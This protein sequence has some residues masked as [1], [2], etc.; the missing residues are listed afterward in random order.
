MSDFTS[1]SSLVS[2]CESPLIMANNSVRIVASS[3]PDIEAW[4]SR[5]S[6]FESLLIP[7]SERKNKRQTVQ[8][9]AT[10]EQFRCGAF[11]FRFR[12]FIST[13]RATRPKKRRTHRK[14]EDIVNSTKGGKSVHFQAFI[15]APRLWRPISTFQTLNPASNFSRTMELSC[16]WSFQLRA[17]DEMAFWLCRTGSQD[18]L[19]MPYIHLLFMERMTFCCHHC[20]QKWGGATSLS[21]FN[22]AN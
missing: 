10:D 19:I 15:L 9:V 22:K 4:I 3:S 21:P 6:P 7:S 12:T 18:K 8:N 13:R 20:E 2:R 11:L 17:I 1:D 14:T 5:I 16:P